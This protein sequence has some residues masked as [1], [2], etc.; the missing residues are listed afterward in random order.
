MIKL[1]LHKSHNFG[2]RSQNHTEKLHNFFLV[3][4]FE[5]IISNTHS[6][7]FFLLFRNYFFFS[8]ITYSWLN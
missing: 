6:V 8:C 2:H 7:V 5:Q 4:F 3:I 1:I